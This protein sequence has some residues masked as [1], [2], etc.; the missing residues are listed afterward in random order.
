MNYEDL[1]KYVYK[2]ERIDYE[3]RSLKCRKR[4]NVQAKQ[5]AMYLG[6]WFFPLLTWEK[7]GQPFNQKHD[8]AI[9]AYNTV[10]N[11]IATDKIYANEMSKYFRA[12][13]RDLNR[14]LQV[15]CTSGTLKMQNKR[16]TLRKTALGYEIK[17]KRLNGREIELSSI[18]LSVEA[19]EG[20][21]DIFEKLNK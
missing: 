18:A 6:H 15:N 9:H 13:R 19:M 16:A 12:V 20:I 4:P 10:C 1:I 17:L 5:R 11:L 21:V 14:H 8:G 2:E 7:I 3:L